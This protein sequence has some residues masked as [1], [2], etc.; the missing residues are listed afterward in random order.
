MEM[1]VQY[2]T[3][4][5]SIYTTPTSH[6]TPQQDNMVD[7]DMEEQYTTTKVVPLT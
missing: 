2:T 4:V 6:K 7:M 5:L 3:T 1:E